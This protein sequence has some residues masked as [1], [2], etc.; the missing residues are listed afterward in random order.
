MFDLGVHR[1]VGKV[2]GAGCLDGQSHAPQ[3]L[4]VP[5]CDDDDDDND[6]SGGDIG[7]DLES[8]ASE[9]RCHPTKYPLLPI[10]TGI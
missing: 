9:D 8:H 5:H 3:H 7:G 4:V 2:H 6:I 1:K 10:Y